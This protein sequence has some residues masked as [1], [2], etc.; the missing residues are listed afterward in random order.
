MCGIWLVSSNDYFFFHLSFFSILWFPTLINITR[1]Q[2]THR[3]HL[4][5]H[6]H[7]RH[8]IRLF[9]QPVESLF[10]H[11]SASNTQNTATSNHYT[12][13][14]KATGGDDDGGLGM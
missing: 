7:I 11:I 8:R 10:R 14:P 1:N 13:K 3:T 2:N 12:I 5:A 4:Q 6:L 9:L